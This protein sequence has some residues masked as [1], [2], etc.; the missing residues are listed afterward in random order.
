MFETLNNLIDDAPVYFGGFI[1]AFWGALVLFVGIRSM[2]L[3]R[4]QNQREDANEM[5]NP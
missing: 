4:E 3:S 2:L 5:T 1:G